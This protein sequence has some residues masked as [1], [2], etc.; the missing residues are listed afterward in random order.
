MRNPEE[1][2]VF[3]A[4]ELSPSIRGLVSQYIANLKEAMPDARASWARDTNIHLTVKFLGE[5]RRSSVANLSSAASRA[6]ASIEPFSIRLENTGVFPNQ[7]QPRVLWIGLTDSSGRL[8]E[9]HKRLE[10]EAA[11]EGFKRESRPFHPHLTVAR[12]RQAANARTLAQAHQQLKFNAAEI[13]VSELLVIRSELSS[14]GSKY[15]TISTHRLGA[16]MNDRAG[17]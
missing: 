15:T 16:N 13:Q 10:D 4:I 11:K 17:S 3:C 6:L 8:G 1:W 5:I 14:A 12:L 9:L 7:R 2:R